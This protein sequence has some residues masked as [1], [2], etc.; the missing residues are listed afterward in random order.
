M[1]E[2]ILALPQGT[3]LNHY[4]IE[5]VLG[6][7]G[8]GVVYKAHHAH[9]KSAVVIK[10]FL[11]L[12]LASREGKTVSPHTASKHDLYVNCLNRFMSEGRT[13]V[14]LSHSNIV[15]CRDLF[16][17][18]GTAYLVMDY[19]EGLALDEL[20]TSLESQGQHYSQAQ[21]LHFLLPLADG[22]AYIHS[23]GVLHRDIKPANIFIRRSDGSPVLIDFGAAKQ[24]FAIASQSQAPYTEFYA[25]MEQIEGGG[26]AKE[27]IDI[28]AFG[29]LMYRIVTGAVG[30]K[31]ESRALALVMGKDDPLISA[32]KAAKGTY[33]EDFLRLIDSCLKFE[34]KDRPQTMEAVKKRLMRV[35]QLNEGSPNSNNASLGLLDDLITMAGSDSVITDSE[36]QLILSKAQSAN[37]DLAAAKNYIL[38]IA[39][40][41]NWQIQST[42]S[43]GTACDEPSEIVSSEINTPK[44]PESPF[45]KSPVDMDADPVEETPE[46][47]KKSLS[48]SRKLLAVVVLVGVSV[49]IAK[50]VDYQKQLERD[51][52]AQAYQ[53][54]KDSIALRLKAEDQR[55]WDKAK[56][57]HS[58]EAYQE[59]LDVQQN[60]RYRN[61]ANSAIAQL[62]IEQKRQQERQ[63]QIQ[64][65]EADWAIAKKGNTAL[66]YQGYLDNG[67]VREHRQE[68]LNALADLTAQGLN[69][70]DAKE[71][72][73]LGYKFDIGKEGYQQSYQQ[74]AYWY[75][76]AVDQ[77]NSGAMNNLGILYK[78]GDGVEQSYAQAL[79]YFRKGAELGNAYAA[80]NLGEMYRDGTGVTQSHQTANKWFTKAVEKKH[81]GAYL[82]LGTQHYHG[83]GLAQSYSEALKYFQLAADRNNRVGQYNVAIMY[84]NGDGVTQSDSE[85][86]KW[87]RLSAKQG[88]EKAQQELE[89]RNLTW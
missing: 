14:S 22:L 80:N 83:R 77:G 48:F 33:S 61:Q 55:A 69:P 84:D 10:E 42:S 70:I 71:Q 89:K 65:D 38:T 79:T 16:T 9:L 1:D 59:Y 5:S 88:Y 35:A 39:T 50:I 63:A 26:E 67:A 75:K 4:I 45:A 36:M 58:E 23:Q 43:D 20:V 32:S 18:N 85:A 11:P 25:P 68:A 72:F 53:Q 56:S 46:H 76:K 81:T 40:Q 8:F 73:S 60:G 28:Y 41:N 74:A 2:N 47:H 27:T 52:L 86:T 66:H 51:R 54:K 78:A 3:E 87:Y 44:K 34:A 82:N 13:L 29:A 62:K 17:A 31:S 6:Q 12:E 30:M 49:G 24:N 19:E 7:G 21:L 15:R 37:I 64:Q 57:R